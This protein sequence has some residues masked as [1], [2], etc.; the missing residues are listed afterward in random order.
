MT[1]LILREPAKVVADVLAHVMELDAAHCLLGDQPW[2]MPPDEAMYVSVHD[3]GSVT[4][5]T[6]T[7]LDETATPPAETMI[8]SAIHDVR[9]EV[10][11]LMPGTSAR[12]RVSE[13]YMALTSFYAQYEMER[14][15]CEMFHPEPVVNASESEPA[16]RLL[17]YVTKVK[18][19]ALHRVVKIEAPYYD[20]FNG[21]TADGSANIPEVNI[22][23]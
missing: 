6:K 9:I 21:A 3:D 2:D 10:I 12:T 16:A 13:V 11:S 8:R 4:V 7:E 22:N 5:S 20:K 23:G 18:V 17:K 19:S 15:C 1:D 14:Y